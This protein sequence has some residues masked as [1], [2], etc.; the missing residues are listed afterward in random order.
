M[1][2][3]KADYVVWI[4]DP[5]EGWYP[6]SVPIQKRQAEKDVKDLQKHG[7]VAK[8]LPDGETP[9]KKAS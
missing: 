7:V 1:T 8:C 2:T 4:N 3:M 6:S 5:L 9:E